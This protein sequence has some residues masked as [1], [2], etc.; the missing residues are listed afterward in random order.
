MT[1]PLLTVQDVAEQL[2][3]SPKTVRIMF[4]RGEIRASSTR[5]GWRTTQ[6]DLDAYLNSTSN[7]PRR[8]K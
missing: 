6:T 4:A 8:N 2:R 1:D 7:R 5:V 3:C